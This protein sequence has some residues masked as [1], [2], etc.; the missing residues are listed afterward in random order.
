MADIADMVVTEGV[1]V[2]APVAARAN[3]VYTRVVE[4]TILAGV[5]AATADLTGLKLPPGTLVL[6][7]ALEVSQDF[8]AIATLA[9]KTETAG[10]TFVAAAARRASASLTIGDGV[11]LAVPTSATA[12]DQV[13]VVLAAA[14]AP[15]TD[16]TCKLTLV[17]T[18]I[19]ESDSGISTFSV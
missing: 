2:P 5:T 7:G 8:G 1:T 9:F 12:D 19:G 14:A 18:T 10:V 3:A 6:G 11:A 15:V 4:F 17:L 13:Q 16:T